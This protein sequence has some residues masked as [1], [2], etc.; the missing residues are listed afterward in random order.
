MTNGTTEPPIK[1]AIW[2]TAHCR[3]IAEK[4]YRLYEIVSHISLSW[5][6]LSVITWSIVHRSQPPGTLLDTYTAVLSV[7]VFAI[8]IVIFGFR[9]GETAA[10]CRECYL[11][12]QKLHA[13]SLSLQDITNQYHEILGAYENHDKKD[14][15]R[16]IMERTLWG[17]RDLWSSDGKKITWSCPML[18]SYALRF[19]TFWLAT[20]LLFLL[21]LVPYLMIFKII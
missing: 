14:F 17:S 5:L 11:R 10:L 20:L 1:S 3:M 4:R 2:L 7:F 18:L 8:S 13:S 15:E 16:L 9:F 6:S 19:T 21:G 12:L